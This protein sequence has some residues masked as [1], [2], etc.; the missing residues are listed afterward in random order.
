MLVSSYRILQSLQFQ[1]LSQ[2]HQ[3]C[4]GILGNNSNAPQLLRHPK[5]QTINFKIGASSGLLQRLLLTTH[6]ISIILA[7]RVSAGSILYGITTSATDHH[8]HFQDLTSV[9]YHQP[10][11]LY[12]TLLLP[13]TFLRILHHTLFRILYFTS[14]SL[15]DVDEASMSQQSNFFYLRTDCSNIEIECASVK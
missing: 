10:S 8:F 2:N 5:R 11:H 9:F 1:I 14:V 12:T 3:L 7:Y 15:V 6:Q 13:V 4:L